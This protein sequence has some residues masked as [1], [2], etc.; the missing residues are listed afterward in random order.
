[1]RARFLSA[2]LVFTAALQAQTPPPA[3]ALAPAA[4]TPSPR[5]LTIEDAVALALEK[6]YD[7]KI[8][9]LTTDSAT[10]SLIIADAAYDPTLSL[11]AT[12]SYSQSTDGVTSQSTLDTRI[13]ASQRVVTGGTISGSGSLDRSRSRPTLTSRFNPV[14][15]SD[16]VLS[17][18]QPLLR[19]AGTAVNRANIERARLGIT[20]ANYDF[21]DSVL[22]TVRNV[23]SAYYDLAYARAQLDVR[24]FSLEVAEKLLE[25]NR[26][27]RDT[28]TAIELD[29]LQ[30]EVG[31]ANARRA[32]LQAEQTAKN[33]EDSL[34]SLINPFQFDVAPGPVVLPDIGAVT[35]SFDRSYKLTRDQAPELASTQLSV[36]QLKLDASVAKNNQLPTLD[37]DAGLGYNARKSSAGEATA[38]VWGSDGYN[39]QVGATVNLPWGLRADKARYRQALTSVN[40]EQ[41]RLQQID[42]SLL[43]QVRSAIRAVETNDESLRIAILATKLSEEQFEAEKARNDNGLST[44]RRVQEAKEDLD[45]AR[46]SELQAKVTLHNAL[47]DLARLEASSLTRYR[48]NLAQ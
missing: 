31:L 47:A 40:R 6:N 7:L 23:E 17:V 10:D 21:K 27:R 13:G 20:R 36:E 45:T 33:A 14:Y 8:Q 26:T 24:R 28:G 3:S 25:E 11:G 1:M 34:L 37:L 42:Q 35:V 5:P 2:L 30:A 19:G 38:D 4:T 29:V 41:I 22:S 12:R 39:W 43:I 48:I 18:S 15:N 32:L 9:R 16:V 46:I 44:F